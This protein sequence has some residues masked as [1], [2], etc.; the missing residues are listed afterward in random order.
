MSDDQEIVIPED[1]THS[2][3]HVSGS[4]A[5]YRIYQRKLDA[6]EAIEPPKEEVAPEVEKPKAKKKK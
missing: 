4:P 5:T 2:D 6:A 1:L 3:G